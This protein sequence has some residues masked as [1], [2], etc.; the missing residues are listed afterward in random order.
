MSLQLPVVECQFAREVSQRKTTGPGPPPDWTSPCRYTTPDADAFANADATTPTPIPTRKMLNAGGHSMQSVTRTV[1]TQVIGDSSAEMEAARTSSQGIS[2]LFVKTIKCKEGP[3][4]E[5][6]M[7]QLHNLLR[8]L[9]GIVA[10][11][12]TMRRNAGLG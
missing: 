7:G 12:R 2:P 4:M 1:W 3:S 9:P 11:E 10:D 6:V 8:E 5:E